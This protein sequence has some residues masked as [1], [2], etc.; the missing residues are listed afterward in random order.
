MQHYSGGW[1]YWE[2]DMEASSH[3]TPYVLRTLISF[4]NL[5]Q[6]I[7]DEVLDNGANYIVSNIATYR[8]SEDDF[9]EAIWALALVGHKDEALELWKNVDTK[10]LTRHGYIAYASSARILG[11]YSD[12]IAIA[13]DKIVLGS[14]SVDYYWYWDATADK[15]LYAQLLLDNGE[16]TKALALLDTLVRST[17]LSSYY[18]STQAKIQIFRALVKQA[19][20]S[21]MTLSK[22]LSMAFRSDAV[23]AD[24]SLSKSKN[25]VTIESNREKIGQKFSL[26]RD[27]ARVPLY[28]TVTIRDRTKSI[29]DMPAQA[30]K[31]MGLIRTFEKV[32]ESK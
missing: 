18:V 25:T 11:T 3:V 31:G 24:A 16:D 13:L 15:A 29:L 32:D 1:T 12:T 30:K 17:D 2:G 23:I 28:V 21:S 9:S 7:P 6:T 14:Q 8:S 4:R 22:T 5:G 19:E 26:K 27:D 20:R 10:K